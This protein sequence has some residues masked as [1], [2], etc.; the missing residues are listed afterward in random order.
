[1]GKKRKKHVNNGKKPQAKK[2]EVLT[3][4]QKMERRRLLSLEMSERGDTWMGDCSS[5]LRPLNY[6]PLKVPNHTT[7]TWTD[8]PGQVEASNEY[9]CF[10]C[11]A[12]AVHTYMNAVARGL[13]I[14]GSIPTLDKRGS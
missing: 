1:M 2:P 5:C 12:P 4:E 3:H 14:Q 7:I 13:N 9:F 8:V 11:Y 10:Q 6:I